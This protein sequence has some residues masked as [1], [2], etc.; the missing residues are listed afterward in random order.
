MREVTILM[1]PDGQVILDGKVEILEAD[2]FS[3][4]SY[5]PECVGESAP[6]DNNDYTIT[7]CYELTKEDK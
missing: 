2:G 4:Q 1:F 6:G 7:Y 3:I 5:E